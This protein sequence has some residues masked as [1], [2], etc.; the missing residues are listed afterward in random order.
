MGA[1]ERVFRN[2]QLNGHE[3]VHL[4]WI[5]PIASESLKSYALRLAARIN[6]NEPFGLVGLSLGGMVATEIASVLH[7][8][9]TVLISSIS[10]SASM[11]PYYRFAGYLRLHKIIPISFL[12][13]LAKWKRLVTKENSADKKMLR[14]MIEESDPHFMRWAFAAALSWKRTERPA[15]CFHIHGSSDAIL[16]MR[17]AKPDHVIP[18]AGHLMVLTRAREIS[19]LLQEVFSQ[20]N[21][22]EDL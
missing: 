9:K 19:R 8:V 5:P 11:P 18:R 20:A 10:C 12:K 3:I 4:N 21:L 14:M 1:D 16:P 6:N 22:K 13:T 2:I 17:F 7:P 15:N